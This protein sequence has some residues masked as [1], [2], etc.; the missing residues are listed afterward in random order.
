M[1]SRFRGVR[2]ALLMF[3]L[4]SGVALAQNYSPTLHYTPSA[5]RPGIQADNTGKNIPEPAGLNKTMLPVT[6]PGA[7]VRPT[8]DGVISP[9]EWTGAAE[10]TLTSPVPHLAPMGAKVWMYND[11]CYLYIAASIPTPLYG[12]IRYSGDASMI[13]MWFDMDRDLI[14]DAAAPPDGNLAIP[15]P[16]MAFPRDVASFLTYDMQANQGYVF[17]TNALLTHVPFWVTGAQ[18]PESQ[19]FVRSTS[20]T[21]EAQY[22][23]AR[24]DI[25]NSPLRMTVGVPVNMR[26]QCYGGY[27]NNTQG[28]DLVIT[29][30]WPYLGNPNAGYFYGN[31][32]NTLD[33]VTPSVV[34]AEPDPYNILGATIA[35]NPA[36]EAKAFVQGDP[37]PLEIDYEGFVLPKVGDY[38]INVYGPLPSTAL[39][40]TITGNFDVTMPLGT[41]I[42]NHLINWERGFYRFEVF[43]SDP[44]DCGKPY[45]SSGGNLLI[46][47]VGDIPCIVWPG[48]VNRDDVVNY[49]DRANLNTYIH[50]ANLQIDWLQGPFRASPAAGPLAAYAWMAQAALPWLTP[51]GCHMDTD[52]SGFVNNF[53]YIAMKVNWMKTVAPIA[54]KD[55]KGA[56]P[57]SCMLEQNY[58]NPF[59]PSTVLTYR[60]SERSNVELIVTDMT[61]RTVARL[62]DREMVAG[63]H[64]A[65]FDAAK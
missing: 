53:D 62:V 58:P 60:T 45:Y 37:L 13:N 3:I 25:R 46:L 33:P 38:Y 36:F 27:W 16:G 21:I 10:L 28:G 34:V 59:N 23:E 20:P 22:T 35:D 49:T 48:D 39:L 51:E 29:G 63:T 26:V 7:V 44:D 15:A 43:V 31:Y 18:I 54:P 2:L 56:L 55:P 42:K 57:T 4:L 6:I 40:T 17:Y 52:G 19:I 65:T 12:G 47:G 24:I 50:D 30:Y 5:N 14:W 11:A 61:G 32:T 8:I 9:G 1:L 41:A 64:S